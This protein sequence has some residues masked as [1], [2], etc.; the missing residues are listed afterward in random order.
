MESFAHHDPCALPPMALRA[1]AEETLDRARRSPVTLVRA[2]A[3]YGKTALLDAWSD[4]LQAE[5]KVVLRGGPE[6]DEAALQGVDVILLDDAHALAP[7]RLGRLIGGMRK[8]MHLILASRRALGAPIA[9][10]R[11]QGTLLELGIEEL[12]L[13]QSEIAGMFGEAIAGK[14]EARTLGWPAGLN[15]AAQ[16]GAQEADF[17]GAWN[18]IYDYFEQEVVAELPAGELEFLCAIAM[19]DRFNGALAGAVTGVPNAAARLI[20]CE[21]RGLFVLPLD[22]QREW[23]RFHPLFAEFLRRRLEIHDGETIRLSCLAASRWFNGRSESATAIDYAL[24]GGDSAGAA[25]I[26]DGHCHEFSATGRQELLEWAERLPP[27]T[28]D[29]HP[30]ILMALAWQKTTFWELARARTLLERSRHRLDAMRETGA[31]GEGELATLEQTMLH[32][33]ILLAQ[34]EDNMP[35]AEQLCRRL[36]DEFGDAPHDVKGRIYTLLINTRR[37]QFKFDQLDRFHALARE[38]NARTQNRLLT[39]IHDS[40]VGYAHWQTGRVDSAL[41]LLRNAFATAEAGADP[42]SLYVT[43]T[44]LPLAELLYEIDERAEA[45]V[46]IERYLPSDARQGLG[47]QLISGWVTRARLAAAEGRIDA[48]LDALAA[49]IEVAES[50]SFERLRLSAGTEQMRI[51]LRQGEPDEAV[52]IAYRLGF[53]RTSEGVVPTAG[54]TVR[55]EARAFG[56]V[57]L[58]QAEG[59]WVDGLRIARQWCSFLV[60]AAA[61]RD[62]VR[63]Q[64]LIAELLFLSGEA[65]AAQRVLREALG[66]AA[67]RGLRRSFMDASPV[68]LGLLRRQ[69]SALTRAVGAPEVFLQS[70]FDAGQQPEDLA[71]G[72]E[73]EGLGGSFTSQELRILMMA[74]T[75]MRN[76]EIGASLAITEGSVKWYLQQIYDKLGVRKRGPALERAR[77]LGLIGRSPPAL[78]IYSSCAD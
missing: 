22:Q 27:E 56:H 51:L 73:Y 13:D 74:G 38:H 33:E 59:R 41:S 40:V 55:D 29:R 63:W 35:G 42:D 24:R 52:R 48:A 61:S 62:H 21:E 26:L 43:G 37:W 47:D 8:G 67:N 1:I 78:H 45:A 34:F 46:L 16:A 11:A 39:A 9:R 57:L 18:S 20:A 23:F 60:S 58:A 68:I 64:L 69:W 15:L 32:R 25:E 5:G 28:L 10:L 19:L 77:Q 4:A 31:V 14:M 65:N 66:H 49:G 50:C 75:G 54:V 70:L 36:L 53:S 7:A 17:S 2:P 72:P 44:A 6:T 30:R 3:G 76:R 12:R 71:V